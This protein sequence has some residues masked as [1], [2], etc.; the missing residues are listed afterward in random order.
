MP[1]MTP[2]S[3]GATVSSALFWGDQPYLLRLAALGLLAER[4]LA[5]TEIDA[6][7]WQGGETADLAT[8]SL[9]G[10]QRALLVANAH[11]LP[12]SGAAELAAYLRSPSP[13]A[14]LVLTVVSRG[15]NAPSLAKVVQAAGGLIGHVSVKR[16]DLPRWV[17][18]RA[19]VR[20]LRLSP[21]GAAALVAAIGEDPAALDQGVEQLSAAPSA[22]TIWR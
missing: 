16:A 8:P 20:D 6:T 17:L 21:P 3:R 22:E 7:E 2:P 11:R 13:E 18:E 15:R 10:D 19:R 1:S 14:V 4:G 9:W 5:P 12:E